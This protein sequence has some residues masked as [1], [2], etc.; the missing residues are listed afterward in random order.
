MVFGMARQESQ[1]SSRVRYFDL[2]NHRIPVS[3]PIEVPWL[4]GR[5]ED[6][7]GKFRTAYPQIDFRNVKPIGLVQFADFATISDAE[8]HNGGWTGSLLDEVANH[9]LSRAALQK[10]FPGKVDSW[11]FFYRGMHVEELEVVKTLVDAFKSGPPQKLLNALA[12]GYFEGD[13]SPF[14]KMKGFGTLLTL[15]YADSIKGPSLLHRLSTIGSYD[16]RDNTV[17][18]FIT[19]HL[20]TL[21]SPQVIELGIHDIHELISQYGPLV[22]L[23]GSAVFEGFFLKNVLYDTIGHEVCHALACQKTENGQII[24]AGFHTKGG[25]Q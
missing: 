5:I 4:T 15:A 7:I 6:T 21:L 16:Y 24:Q 11:D 13:F 18:L 19:P 25:I 10:E 8:T 20:L 1:Y 12:K 22:A 2:F 9:Y 23:I 3:A 14:K 17:C